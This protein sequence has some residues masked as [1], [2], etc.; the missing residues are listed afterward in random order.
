MPILFGMGIFLVE[1]ATLISFTR[2]D[3]TTWT[4]LRFTNAKCTE[5]NDID[6]LSY[7]AYKYCEGFLCE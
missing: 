3:N 7:R 4:K 1:I 2:N 5:R 6:T